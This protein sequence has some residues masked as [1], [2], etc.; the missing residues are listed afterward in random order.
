MK[1]AGNVSLVSSRSKNAN[2]GHRSSMNLVSNTTTTIATTAASSM[3]RNSSSRPRANAP[4]PISS[5]SAYKTP[6]T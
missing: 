1:N 6:T 4:T 2:S 3:S 5:A